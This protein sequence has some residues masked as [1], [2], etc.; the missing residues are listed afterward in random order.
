MEKRPHT[1]I[2]HETRASD[3]INISKEVFSEEWNLMFGIHEAPMDCPPTPQLHW[4]VISCGKYK[5]KLRRGHDWS[6]SIIYYRVAATLIVR[7]VASFD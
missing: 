3:Q 5:K 2:A 7:Q 4:S 6:N 1:P